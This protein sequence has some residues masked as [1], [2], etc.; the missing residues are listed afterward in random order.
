MKGFIL[1]SGLL[2]FAAPASAQSGP[3]GRPVPE[4][5]ALPEKALGEPVAEIDPASTTRGFKESQ[6]RFDR[7]ARARETADERMRRRFAERGVDYPVKEIFIRVFKHE[8][9]LE[10]WARSSADEAFRLVKEYPV[11]ALPGQL[12]PKSRMGDMQV[13]E[14]FYFI[15]NFNPRSAYRLSL[16]LS[17]PN[18]GDRLR[19]Y[20]M[21]LGGDIFIHGGCETI[22]CIPI[23]NA[24]IDEVYWVAVQA[25]DAGQ[26]VIPVHVFPTRMEEDR[27]DWLN[28]VYDPDPELRE[29]WRNIAHGYAFF[30]ET[31]RVPW[32]TIG[33]DGSYVVP[34]VPRPAAAEPATL[35]PPLPSA[36]GRPAR[37][38]G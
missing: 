22:G 32:V 5:P 16:G 34:S 25:T 24:N 10:L 21:S 17:Y 6:L 3:L 1:A 33:E 12:G 36:T 11:C 29:F 28:A 19:G 4:P 8:K 9:V 7:V 26:R 2:V 37:S 14:G 38:G 35:T 13:P 30:E 15:D 20:T 18:L 27:V 31:R 23:E